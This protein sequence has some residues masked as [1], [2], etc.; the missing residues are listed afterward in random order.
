MSTNDL[1]FLKE[2]LRMEVIGEGH[3]FSWRKAFTRTRR[4]RRK[5]FM[6]WWRVAC[7]LYAQGG[8]KKRI[9]K[10]IEHRLHCRFSVEI[11]LTVSVAPGLD[12]AHMSG[13]VITENCVIGKN[14]HLKHG[15][16]IGLRTDAKDALIVI[17]DN[18]DIGCNSSVLGGNITIGD[19][20]TIGAHAL[21]LNSIQQNQIY[22]NKITQI[23]KSKNEVQ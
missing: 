21:V 18:V 7:Y 5:Y 14:L 1:A 13:I 11:P 17:G 12:L 4:N 10:S 6:F 23:I 9:A 16:T 8:I 3:N 22:T 19:N 20:V 2:C 15:V